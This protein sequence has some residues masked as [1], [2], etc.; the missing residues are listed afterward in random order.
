[1]IWTV[2]LSLIGHSHQQIPG[3]GLNK[4]AAQTRT[5]GCGGNQRF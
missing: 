1:M 3:A 2:V 4:A 5:S